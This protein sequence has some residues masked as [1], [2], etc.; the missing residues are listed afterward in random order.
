MYTKSYPV[1][2]KYIHGFKT[3][4]LEQI[5]H[6]SASLWLAQQ[7]D[8]GT[9]RSSWEV[10]LTRC[11]MGLETVNMP[12]FFQKYDKIYIAFYTFHFQKYKFLWFL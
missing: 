6:V 4:I 2:D 8:K 1:Y 11:K 5:I 7:T 9:G 10:Y 12:H 3:H